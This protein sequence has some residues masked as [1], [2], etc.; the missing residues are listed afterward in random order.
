MTR[1]ALVLIVVGAIVAGCGAG[2]KS[3]SVA[4]LGTHT[5]STTQDATP[6]GGGLSSGGGGGNGFH[7]A[8]LANVKYSQCMRAHGVRNFPDPGSNGEVGIS[9]SS[10]IDPRSPHFQAAQKACAKDLPNGGQPT[11]QQVAKMKKAALAFSACMRAHGVKDY[12]DP[13]F[14]GGGV[15]IKVGGKPGSD[16]DPNNPIFHR[17]QQACRGDLPVP[18]P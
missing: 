9:S 1:A 16:L 7:I 11:P 18:K 15:S 14:R 3:P 17:A 12:P 6:S 8:M 5:T 2:A 4:S 10:G 13:D